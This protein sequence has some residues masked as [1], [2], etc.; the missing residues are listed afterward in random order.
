MLLKIHALVSITEIGYTSFAH[1]FT[2]FTVAHWASAALL[3]AHA[4][5]AVYRKVRTAWKARHTRLSC[6]RRGT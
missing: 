5:H 6:R 1:G 4:V 3:A 2:A